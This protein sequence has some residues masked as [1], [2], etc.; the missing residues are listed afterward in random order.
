VVDAALA[1]GYRCPRP[2]RTR[3]PLRAPSA[4]A[5]PPRRPRA[6]GAGRGGRCRNYCGPLGQEPTHLDRPDLRRSKLI[7]D[8]AD[9]RSLGELK[10]E[11]K[12]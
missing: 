4:H 6:A 1:V 9:W 5:E 3:S 10:R 8:N 2:A 12:V 7:A 11:M